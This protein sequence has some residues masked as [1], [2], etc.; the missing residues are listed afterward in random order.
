MG[1]P[2]ELLEEMWQGKPI[3]TGSS[4]VA[5]ATLKN[6]R[7]GLMADSPEEQASG[8]IRLLESP[9]LAGRLGRHAHAEV[10]RRYLVTHHLRDY[11]RLLRRLLA[12]RVS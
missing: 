8:I 12:R 10:A 3:V 6:E 11:L 9:R 4:S 2:L 7:T 1:S 5:L